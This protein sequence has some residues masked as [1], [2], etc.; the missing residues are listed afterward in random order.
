MTCTN[1]SHRISRLVLL[2]AGAVSLAAAVGG[3]HWG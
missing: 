3:S 1:L 2:V